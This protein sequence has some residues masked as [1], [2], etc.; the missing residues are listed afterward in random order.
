MTRTLWK[1]FVRSVINSKGRFI[2]LFLLMAL[3]SFALIGLKVTGPNM[4]KS[5]NRFLEDNKVMDLT[6]IAG[7]GFTK[8]D[9]KELTNI[10]HVKLDYSH[11]LDANLAQNEDAIRLFSTPKNQSL[12]P[13][14]KGRYPKNNHEIALAS[15]LEKDYPIGQEIEIKTGKSQL[16]E[17]KKFQVVGYI[18]S[19]ELWSKNN[20]GNTVAGDGQLSAY[21]ILSDLAFKIP[22]NTVRI[23]YSD[24]RDFNAFSDKYEKR[25]SEKEEN[26]RALF[27]D[28]AK[29]ANQ[30]IESSTKKQI[31]QAEESLKKA[32]ED[33]SQQEALLEQLPSELKQESQNH[34]SEVRKALNVK[35]EKLNQTKKEMTLLPKASYSIFNRHQLPGG[36]GYH[37]Y[38]TSITSIGMVSNIFPVVLYLVAA[39]VTFTTMTRFVDEERLNS[40]LLQAM[41]YSKQAILSKFL[42][43]GLLASFLGTTVG[44]LGGSY[45]LSPLIAKIITKPMVLGQTQLDFYV[46][47]AGIAYLLALLSAI[48]PAYLI[49]RKELHHVPAQLLLPKPPVKGAKVLLERLPFLWNRLSF[50]YKVTIRNIFRYKQRMLMTIFGVA[51]SV[52]LL[53]SGLGIQSSLSKVMDHQFQKISPYDLLLIEKPDVSKNT[54]RELRDYLDSKEVAAYQ[55]VNFSAPQF[56]IKGKNNLSQVSL[57]TSKGKTFEPFI[58]LYEETTGKKVKL[59][60]DGIVMSTKLASFYHVKAGQKVNLI[61]DKKNQI[62]VRVSHIIDMNVGHF[63]LVNQAYF[64]KHFTAIKSDKAYLI[65]LKKGESVSK[66]AKTLLAFPA[67]KALS[68][69]SQIIKSVKEIVQSL[70][71]VM[72]LLVILS[73]LLALVILYNLTTINIAER[74]RELSTIKVLGFYDNE[75]GLY[76][77]RETI[78][79][80]LVG[81]FLG[82]ISGQQLHRLMIGLIGA[83]NMQFG[84]QVDLHVYLLPIMAICF[85]IIALGIIVYQRLKHL[86]MLDALKSID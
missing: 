58:N 71:Q 78:I 48:L 62:R 10:E 22:Q 28:N 1:D 57:I 15:W 67:V 3:G 17:N 30:D 83:D 53:F 9:K 60:S 59:R 56:Q 72:T 52:A 46:T 66:S 79:L 35:E 29:V 73:L 68:Q 14:I 84:Q 36:E 70:N 31:I 18:K 25:L 4:E 12:S 39:L 20:L 5:A 54:K 40:G 41:G 50:T 16:L 43:Y 47:Y 49:V 19:S 81:I 45:I 38:D 13:L 44:I 76:I 6:I 63:I 7:R 11:Q 26:L 85:L 2:S 33:L 32:K 55:E 74:I 24:L 21:A 51:G 61:D 27:S 86:E 69:N 77:Y 37:I 8:D 42:I 80:S 23:R 64:D 82:I 75:L 34:L 65:N